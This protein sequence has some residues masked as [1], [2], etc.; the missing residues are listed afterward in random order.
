MC[1]DNALKS[2]DVEKMSA[3]AKAL[4]VAAQ[5]LPQHV[6]LVAHSEVVSALCAETEQKG[7]ETALLEACRQLLNTGVDEVDGELVDGLHQA[8]KNWKPYSQSEESLQHVEGFVSDALGAGFDVL[9]YVLAQPSAAP[10]F[11]SELLHCLVP[12]EDQCTPL[13]Y[14]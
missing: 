4:S 5:L 9:Q 13:S 12:M 10:T 6:A 14:L 8:W 2:L 1:S 11:V 3:F 7:A